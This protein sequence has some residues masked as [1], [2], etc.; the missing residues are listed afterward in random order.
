MVCRDI[1]IPAYFID[2]RKSQKWNTFVGT[3]QKTKL[4]KKH[5]MSCN[6]KMRLL[7]QFQTM[8]HRG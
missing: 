1:Q 5:K 7:N 8:Y 3:N 4:K 6:K 2:K